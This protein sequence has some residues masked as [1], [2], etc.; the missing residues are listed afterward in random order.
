MASAC[1]VSSSVLA[2][3]GLTLKVISSTG[4]TPVEYALDDIRKITFQTDNFTVM[5]NDVAHGSEKFL[6]EDVQKMVFGTSTTSIDNVKSENGSE[7]AISYDGRTIKVSGCEETAQLR[8]FDIS[9]RPVI[10]E[11]VSGEA[12]VST[13]NLSTGVY[14]LRVNNK[15]FKFSKF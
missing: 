1:L 4:E 14:I 12:L 15:T 9:G 7:I 6:Y 10:S 8:V 11:I 2:D 13:E 3:D 5:F